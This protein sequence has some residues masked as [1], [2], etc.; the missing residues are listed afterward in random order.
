MKKTPFSVA[1]ALAVAF[2]SMGSLSPQKAHNPWMGRAN[3]SECCGGEGCSQSPQDQV[4]QMLRSGPEALDLAVQTLRKSPDGRLKEVAAYVIGEYGKA[5]LAQVLADSLTDSSEQFR[6]AAIT[7]FQ[8]VVNPRA[9]ERDPGGDGL[10][11]P[12]PDSLPPNTGQLCSAL[13]P[14]LKDRSPLVRGPAA[15][16]IGWLR[17]DS[18][19]VDLQELMRDPFER[20]RF[21][22]SHALERLTGKHAN[23]INLDDVVWGRP[24][25]LTVRKARDSSEAQQAGPFLRTAFFEG[26]GKFS[27]TGGVPAQFQTVLQI[28]WTDGHLEFETECQDER[29]AEDGGDKLTFFLRPQG[30]SKLYKFV[31][32]PGRGLVRQAIE[33]PEGHE[34]EAQL[35]A[36]ASV[37]RNSRVWK[38][39]LQVPFQVFGLHGVPVGDTW[40]ANV[41][42]TESHHSTGWGAEIS[43]WTYFHRDFP[44]PPRLGNLYFAEN[45]PVLGFRP[46][47]DNVY[48]FPFDQ[49][50]LPED[51][52]R[53]IR[54]D[55]ETLWGD[56]VAP[57]HLLQSVNTFFIT[58]K[59][60]EADPP[61]LRLTVEASDFE[62]RK[63]I[64][65]QVL[66]LSGRQVTGQRV[67]LKLPESIKSRALDLEVVVSGDDARHAVFRTRFISV[68]VVSPPKRVTLYHLS[69]VE[70][71]KGL[72]KADS[73]SP[74]EWAIR[75]YGPMLMS[76]SYPMALLEGRNGTLYCGTYPGGR[77]FSFSPATGVLE[78]LGSP[79]PPANHL[80]DLVASPDDRLYGDLYR[81]RGRFFSYA[82][83]TRTSVDWGVPVP[84]AF[85][86]ECRVMTWTDGRAYGTQ[87]G[88]LFFAESATDRIVDKGSFFLN[89]KRYL[90]IQIASDTEG[91]LLGIAGGRLFQYMS[92]SDVVRISD[93]ELNGW[94]LPGPQGKLYTL[95]LDGRLFR[96][97]PDKDELVEVTRYAPIPLG[98]GP[99][100]TRYR[101]RGIRLVLT[102]TE[103]LVVARSG[104]DD[105][106]QT[107]LW[108]YS[109]GGSPP[110]NLGNP[111]AG[112]LYLNGLTL[113]TRNTVY[114]MSAQT[115]YGLGRTPVHLYSLARVGRK[116]E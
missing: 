56:I 3:A 5:E 57:D 79:S 42:R 7:A 53:P 38:A 36:Q 107:A 30:Q 40:E 104:I 83:K 48:T 76:E 27:Y 101:F 21:Q 80:Y 51:Q 20:V 23:F 110:V 12:P 93:V 65:S 34:N 105:P 32:A 78:D 50:S 92:G 62:D 45:A 102:G 46:A 11:L 13:Q 39:H 44:G 77:L 66:H 98:V 43:S 69:R 41:V 14:L 60:W 16:T 70:D 10:V 26:Q 89:G 35:N 87:R 25:L 106:K 99:L 68:P 112:S 24:P 74:G 37:E 17:C 114:G 1:V 64:T 100:Y 73:V 95:F 15:E 59:D 29:P 4:V 97:E 58:R 47:P 88:H 96:W 72:W 8:K 115:V 91:N 84:G 54:P 103:E 108:I 22:A 116:L 49:D 18:S 33:T 75:D 82:L 90:P 61:T 67:E 86:G 111:V 81:P 71:E 28:W 63:V 2:G 55:E 113:G 94:L 31:V 52:T 9:L 85:S 19:I 6:R 109:A